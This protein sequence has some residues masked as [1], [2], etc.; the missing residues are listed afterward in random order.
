MARVNPLDLS[1]FLDDSV[2]TNFDH[3]TALEAALEGTYTRGIGDIKMLNLKT[4]NSY[5]QV[6]GIINSGLDFEK[7]SWSD[8]TIKALI[9]PDF[10]RMIQPV[11]GDMKI[12]ADLKFGLKSSGNL[13]NFFVDGNA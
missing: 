8:M 10:E 5:F 1:Y 7:I 12:P 6:A 4:A 9:G 2:L 11:L 3:W 13:K